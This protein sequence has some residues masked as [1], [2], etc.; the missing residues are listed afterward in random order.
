MKLAVNCKDTALD[1]VKVV[2]VTEKVFW[3][4]EKCLQTYMQMRPFKF[5]F[6]NCRSCTTRV[7]GRR[8]GVG[9]WNNRE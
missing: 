7:S 3:W 8:K 6:K 2:Q 1:F 9:V 5:S 4:V